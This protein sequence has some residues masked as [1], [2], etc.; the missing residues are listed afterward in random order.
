[1]KISNAKKEI[2]RARN[3]ARTLG[4]KNAAVYLKNRGWSVEAAAYILLGA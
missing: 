2:Y 4:L 3:I 1:M